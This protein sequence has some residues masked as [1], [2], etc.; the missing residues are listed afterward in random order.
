MTY[1]TI[2]IIIFS[3]LGALDRI[4]GNRFG[5]GKE[6]EK[7]FQLLGAMA[8]SMI[9]MIVL[10]PF[11]AELMK[12]I[13]DF[14]ADKLHLDASI[15]PALL[16]ANDM[17]G[18]SLAVEMAINKEIGLYHA[19]VVSSMMGCTISFTVPYALGV[20]RKE[21]HN[22][23]LLGL[24]CGVVTIPLG[25]FV[26]GLV[27]RIPITMLLL[28]LL[29]LVI[30]SGVIAVGLFLLPEM[31]IKIF[32]AFGMLITAVITVGLSLGMINFL[33]GREIFKGLATINEGALVCV[34]ASV[35]LSGSFP[36]MLVLAKLLSRPLGAIG[37]RMG[38][39][40]ISVIGFV[41]GLASSA[42][43]FGMMDKM[44]KKGVVM[45]AAFCVSG[46]FTVGS[47]L[48]FTMAFDSTYVLPV[49]VGKLIAGV[50]AVILS[51]IIYNKTSR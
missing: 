21:Q 41:S 35:V 43:S 51:A 25:C 46:A 8:L 2:A 6:F 34:N 23:L 31:C 36:L 42:T 12:P 49:V 50:S 40:E 47:H 38:L 11:F 19:L 28:H 4:L 37:K 48:A 18:A 15:V 17:G 14:M 22:D 26:S 16:F 33:T 3:V 27:C 45:N 30:L 24:L 13:S 10:A 5:L 9:G 1:L 29:P 7:A 20:V 39:N 44:D 32:K